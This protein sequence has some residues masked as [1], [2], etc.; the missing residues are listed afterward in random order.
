MSLLSVLGSACSTASYLWQ[1]GMGQME[2]FNRARPI[3]EVI[4][5][6]KT[7]PRIRQLL[8]D[9]A[10]M[11]KFGEKMG[12]KPTR[13]YE[14]YVRLDRKVVVY[15]V[16]GSRPLAFKPYEW[17]FPIVGS[18]PYLGFF[19]REDAFRYSRTIEDQG[20]DVDV[21][22]AQAYSTLG[23]FRDPVLSSMI[24]EGDEAFGELANV[25]LHES[26]HATY[27]VNDQS[28][29]NESL[30]SFVAD[31]MTPVFLKERFG[32]SSVEYKSYREAD[33]KSEKRGKKMHEAYVK[34]EKLYASNASEADKKTEKDRIIA[35][36]KEELKWPKERAMNN[37][38][39]FQF[40]TYGG[41]SEAFKSLFARCEKNWT[42]FF[43]KIS[44]VNEKSFSKKQS[45][46][47]GFLGNI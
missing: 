9:V 42:Q 25:I 33:E 36:L 46:D 2:L 15:V 20:W 41:G 26:V 7:S 12:L 39:L 13:N 8:A 29:F 27:Y 32:E 1:A 44:K 11:K 31:E 37:A 34:L 43:S 10:I 3:S 21:R 4:T 28:T 17:S 35:G 22:G 23:W 45:E 6:E 38:T 14:H 16:S 24:P 47:L 30:A 19:D 18:F 5:D 40:K